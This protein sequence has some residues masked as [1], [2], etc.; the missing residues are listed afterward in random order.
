MYFVKE[1]QVTCQGQPVLL[2]KGPLP[3]DIDSTKFVVAFFFSSLIS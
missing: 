2:T 1:A 3:P